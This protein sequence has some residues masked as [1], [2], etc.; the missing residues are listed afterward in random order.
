MVLAMGGTMVSCNDL[1]N[2]EPQSSITPESYYKAEDQIQAC[3]NSF[4][5]NLPS[6]GYGYGLYSSDTNTDNQA[7]TGSDGKYLDGQWKVGLTNGNWGFGTI[8]D[9]NYKLNTCLA[10]YK[11]G[12]I[13]GSDKNI[14]QYLGELYFFPCLGV[15]RQIEDLGR[16][17]YRNRGAA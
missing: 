5:G 6:H 8:R 1:L 9:I 14:R 12:K 13:S 11:A 7:G 3:A 17:P 15:F 2:Q 16:F 10:N 4:Y